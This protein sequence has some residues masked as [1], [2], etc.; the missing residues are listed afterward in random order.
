MT[1]ATFVPVTLAHR[2]SRH[3]TTV[4]PEV[5]TAGGWTVAADTRDGTAVVVWQPGTEPMQPQVRGML[6][7]RW[8]CSLRA[9]GFTAEARVDM[10]PFGRLV[11]SPDGIARWLHVTS[12]SEP[13]AVVAAPLPPLPPVTPSCTVPLPAGHGLRCPLSGLVPTEVQFTY[14][15]SGVETVLLFETPDFSWGALETRPPAWLVALA[16]EHRPGVSA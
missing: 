11:D 4:F 6:L 15:P 14:R 12:W 1:A 13:D 8:L 16:E 10:T 2:V 7:Y 9:A 5:V 3:M